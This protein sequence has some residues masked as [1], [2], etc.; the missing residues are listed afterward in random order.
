MSVGPV[1]IEF[2][3]KGDVDAQLKRVSQTVAG[4]SKALQDQVAT[5]GEKFGESFD[6][7]ATSIAGMQ[8]RLAQL[9]KIYSELS[10]EGRSSEFGK[11]LTDQIGALEGS[12][13]KA[14]GQNRSFMDSITALPGP[15]GSAASEMQM[16]TK[17]ALRFIATPIGAVIA[18]IVVALKALTTWFK[19]SEEGENALAEASA[20]FK[21][22]LESL[23]NPVEKVGEW[24]WKA[25]TKPKE[26]LN[27]L[28]DFMKGQVINRLEAIGDAGRAIMRIFT[29][30]FKAGFADLRNAGAQF[31]T[32]IEDAGPKIAGFFT[33]AVT[34]TK[35]RVELTKQANLL[36]AKVRDFAL[37]RA[38]AE[39][40]IS[41]MRFKATDQDRPASERLGY[42]KQAAN[43]VNALYNK[44]ISLAQEKLNISR[45]IAALDDK[46]KQDKTELIN[47]EANVIRLQGQRADELRSLSRQ[48]NTLAKQSAETDISGIEKLQAELEQLNKSILDAGADEQKVMAER[49]VKLEKELEL[50]LRIAQIAILQARNTDVPEKVVPI[51]PDYNRIFDTSVKKTGLELDKLKGKINENKKAAEALIKLVG[52]E[53]AEKIQ[54]FI[55]T[56]NEVLGVVQNIT[57]EYAKQLGLTEEQAKNAD[58]ILQ[59]ISGA[60]DI[61][62]GNYIQGAAKIIDSFLSTFL[63]ADQTMQEHFENLQQNIEKT[64]NSIQ[65]V[66]QTL[67]NLGDSGVTRAI[68]VIESQ[69]KTVGK[70]AQALNKELTNKTYG[71]RRDFNT[72]VYKD[73]QK[74]I[75]DIEKEI[76]A[77]TDKL[78][79]GQLS[80]AQRKSIEAVLTSY[81][82]LLEGLD[83]ITQEIIGTTVQSLSEGIAE[84]FLSGEDAAEAWGQKVNDIIKYIMVKELTADL[85]TDKI[86]GATDQLVKDTEGGLTKEEGIKF[87]ETLAAIT[88]EVGPAF[89][90]ARE[91][92]KAIGIDMGASTTDTKGLSGAI[93]GITEETGSLIGGQLMGIRYDVKEIIR[94]MLIN[95]EDMVRSLAYQAEI[96]SNTRHNARLVNINEQLEKM[97]KTLEARL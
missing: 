45:G 96:A 5:F 70:E 10:E 25:F 2:V 86:K 61:L 93:S 64:L 34:A 14:E 83:N 41:E 90:A 92:L 16:M 48:T 37:E 39:A 80:D 18:A 28:V 22:V 13:K 29:G 21:Q 62:M 24:L 47:L 30:E 82:Q 63:K 26:A 55:G 27:D 57:Q 85:L 56:T 3:L 66:G 74:Q 31:T 79:R 12:I 53:K 6:K 51:D 58:N 72:S 69:L 36:E 87:K 78:L 9:K 1:D 88:T 20:V 52:A 42:M 81:N 7:A 44:E 84:A 54:G 17:A 94:R 38:K 35:Q 11:V 76:T 4:E 77:L 65:I 91:A 68:S 23:L 60:G 40:T 75:V 46:T 19:S 95:N 97:N 59:G 71:P 89:E 8:E 67:S 73:I 43:E 15:L 33:D 32:G 49:I 50:R